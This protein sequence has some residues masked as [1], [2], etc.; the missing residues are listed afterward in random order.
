MPEFKCDH[1]QFITCP[2]CG[3]EDENSWEYSSDSTVVTC[4]ACDKEFDMC[5]DIEVYYTTS[6]LNPEAR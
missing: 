6:K 1:T 4:G 3:H 5:R 2:Y